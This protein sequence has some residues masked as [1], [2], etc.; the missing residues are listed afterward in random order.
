MDKESDAEKLL[1][2]RA[3]ASLL[4]PYMPGKDALSW[5]MRDSRHDPLIPCVI[6]GRQVLYFRSDL[7]QFVQKTFSVSATFLNMEEK[8]LIDRRTEER[9]KGQERRQRLE[10][11]LTPG[12]ERRRGDGEDR[13]YGRDFD[14]RNNSTARSRSR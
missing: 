11:R 13:R 14:R 1:P 6:R 9:R 5:L 3:A 10:V 4:Q 7:A 2:L 12:V 8:N